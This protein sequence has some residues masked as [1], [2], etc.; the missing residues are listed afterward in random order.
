MFTYRFL[1]K[2]EFLPLLGQ[3]RP[4][5]F[6]KS[7][8][9]DLNGIYSDEENQR[10]KQLSEKCVTE[11]RLYLTAWDSENFVGWSWGYQK[12]GEEFY[13]CNSA[14]MSEYRRKK[15]YSE[16]MRKIILKATADGFKEITSKHHADNNA[17]IIPKLKA[18]FVI[19]GFEINAKF[20]LMINLIF[21]KNSKIL[22]VH[23]MRTGL[24]K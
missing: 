21:Y 5:I 1:T 18:G 23:H 9:I 11:Y 19:Q 2:E 22:E 6:S 12:S 3:Y 10:S 15:I 24:M 14:V 16:M 4:V 7:N 20:G 13:M 17:V 8:D